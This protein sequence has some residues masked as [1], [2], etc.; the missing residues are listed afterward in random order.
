[1]ETNIIIQT[2]LLAVLPLVTQGLKRIVWIENN[3]AWFC[4]LLCIAASTV[5][6][7][8]LHL[9]DWLLIGI[10]TGA[11]CN[12]V[13]DWSKDIKNGIILVPVAF[14]MLLS[15]SGCGTLADKK[16][17]VRVGYA[18]AGGIEAATSLKVAG[19]LSP[20]DVR[21]IDSM[22][23]LG[24]TYRKQW[25]EALDANQPPPEIAIRGL[26][27]IIDRL[28]EIQLAREGG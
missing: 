13:Y 2:A 26:N 6:A 3:K 1:M 24:Q 4:P 14:F 16:N 11:A 25:R 23:D 12:K 18:F 5:A 17:Y 7:Y 22:I 8:F 19:K 28:I 21:Q 20:T 27:D 10:L 15:L 9:P